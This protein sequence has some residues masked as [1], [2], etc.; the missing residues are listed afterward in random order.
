MQSCNPTEERLDA[1]GSRLQHSLISQRVALQV[2]TQSA[3]TC[4]LERC[5]GSRVHQRCV[6]ETG[7][8]RGHPS[9]DFSILF[10]FSFFRV[11][12]LVWNYGKRVDVHF[13]ALVLRVCSESPRPTS[14]PVALHLNDSLIL[15][16][17][18][19]P[20]LDTYIRR[21]CPLCHRLRPSPAHLQPALSSQSTHSTATFVASAAASVKRHLARPYSRPRLSSHLSALVVA[22]ISR[23]SSSHPHQRAQPVRTTSH[24]HPCL[25][26]SL[27]TCGV[28]GDK[29]S[30]AIGHYAERLR[31]PHHRHA[32]R[33]SAC[34]A[35]TPAHSQVMH[36][37]SQGK[38]RL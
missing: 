4:R 30:P 13:G 5:G 3:N 17:P 23:L 7:A 33:R 1:R 9:R 22:T 37:L 28:S 6:S 21:R 18:R 29:L 12:F 26:L 24:L 35:K 2:R 34:K 19:I 20:P 38:T 8:S 27:F 14:N 16:A 31:D 36:P 10:S 32:R 15:I 25:S 11:F